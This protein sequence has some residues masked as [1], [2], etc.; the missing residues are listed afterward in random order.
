MNDLISETKSNLKRFVPNAKHI[1]IKVERDRKKFL[2]KIHVHVPRKILH[3]EKEADSVWEALDSSYQA[4]LKQI[5]RMK[6]KR[7]A[8]KKFIRFQNPEI[9]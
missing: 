9:F 8:K 1:F 4:V 7:Q 3:A 2:S 6:T 5:E